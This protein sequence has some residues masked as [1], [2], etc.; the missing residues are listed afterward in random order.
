MYIK[1][2]CLLFLLLFLFN[3]L[4]FNCNKI[5]PKYNFGKKQNYKIDLLYKHLLGCNLYF[6]TLDK[7][8][9]KTIYSIILYPSTSLII[10]FKMYTNDNYIINNFNSGKILFFGLDLNIS[11]TDITLTQYNTDSIICFFNN[12]KAECHDYVYDINEEKY[13]INDDEKLTNNNLIPSGFND[14]KLN[15]LTED[16]ID[17]TNYYQISFEKK[18]NINFDNITMFNWINTVAS[19][20]GYTV[21]GFYGFKNNLND[22]DYI[23]IEDCYLLNNIYFKD[24]AGLEDN[25]KINKI[26]I[27]F[28]ILFSIFLF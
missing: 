24:G 8:T 5:K 7:E 28:I 6:L 9:Y 21:N 2:F 17:F 12:N 18:Y 11:N 19:E 20:M 13:K 25:S 23:R 4:H 27:F 15:I 1:T 14:I 22:I 3:F 16:V 26:H 10:N